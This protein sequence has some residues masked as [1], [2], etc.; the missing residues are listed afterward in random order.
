MANGTGHDHASSGSTPH[1][2]QV[3]QSIVWYSASNKIGLPN[4]SNVDVGPAGCQIVVDAGNE[5]A[6]IEYCAQVTN[7]VLFAMREKVLEQVKKAH[8]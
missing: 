5:K 4:Y 1:S 2:P 6:G 3:G 7:E 8:S